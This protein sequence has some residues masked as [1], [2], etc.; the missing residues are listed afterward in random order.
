MAP[1]AFLYNYVPVTVAAA[2][3]GKA[4]TTTI[5]FAGPSASSTFKQNVNLLVQGNVQLEDNSAAL[6]PPAPPSTAVSPTYTN[7]HLV[8]TATGNIGLDPNAMGGATTFYWPGL[9]YLT[10]GATASNPTAAPNSTASIALGDTTTK[11]PSI[12]ATS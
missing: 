10:S 11:T 1:R 4:G 2:G 7:N 9:V 6:T 8:V 12:S 3:G 5:S